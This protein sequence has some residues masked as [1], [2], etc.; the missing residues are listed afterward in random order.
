VIQEWL[1]NLSGTDVGGEKLRTL[2]PQQI[3]LQK[4]TG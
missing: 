2:R 3:A 4:T 1:P